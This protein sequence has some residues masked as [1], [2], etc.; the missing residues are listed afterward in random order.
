M[1]ENESSIHVSKDEEHSAAAIGNN[2]RYGQML[3][4]KKRRCGCCRQHPRHRQQPRVFDVANDLLSNE[5]PSRSCRQHQ[6]FEAPTTLLL[7]TTRISQPSET[8]LLLFSLPIANRPGTLYEQAH[9]G[10]R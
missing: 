7:S 1:F 2:D 3:Y 6:D 5:K 10:D 9:L 4:V 8:D